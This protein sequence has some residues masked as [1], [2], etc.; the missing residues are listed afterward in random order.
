MAVSE[1]IE[2]KKQANLRMLEN[3]SMEETEKEQ[4]RSLLLKTVDST[5][6]RTTEEKVQDIT[7]CLN[8]IVSLSNMDKVYML[9]F[10]EQ[11]EKN[12]QDLKKAI[13]DT[14]DE[15]READKKSEE[16]LKDF[17]KETNDHFVKLTEKIGE[18]GIQSAKTEGTIEG[19]AQHDNI[20]IKKDEV[21]YGFWAKI[22]DMFTG[23]WPAVI[24]TAIIVYFLSH[25]S[26]LINLAR[27]IVLG[28]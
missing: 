22:A 17:R 27:A 24:L 19:A 21:K 26:E 2:L 16:E 14:R 18:L 25:S 7:E 10:R 20:E 28:Q 5:N 3:S 23:R 11:M 13:E 9:N 1:E 4:R 8:G 6:G 12:Q 15:S